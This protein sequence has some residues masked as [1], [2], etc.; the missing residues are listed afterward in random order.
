MTAF[1]VFEHLDDPLEEIKKMLV[2]S[3]NILFS[4][5]L[6][7]LKSIKDSTDWWYIAPETGQHIAFYTEKSLDILAQKLGLKYYKINN[8]L[9][10]FSDQNINIKWIATIINNSKLGF[11]Y[12]RL[13]VKNRKSFLPSDY[14][15]IIGRKVL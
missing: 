10:L 6:Q 5:E 4:T 14:N 9:H 15:T 7:P 2:F 3:N 12:K 13:F 8:S 11:L 1:E